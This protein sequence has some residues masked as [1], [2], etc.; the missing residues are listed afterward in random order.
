MKKTVVL[1]LILVINVLLIGCK[2]DSV[3]LKYEKIAADH[4][5]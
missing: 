5:I 4:L 2:N 3:G 1:I